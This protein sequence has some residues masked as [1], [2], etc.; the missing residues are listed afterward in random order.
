MKVASRGRDGL[1]GQ[2]VIIINMCM[3]VDV[4]MGFKGAAVK[5]FKLEEREALRWT[6]SREY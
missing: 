3:V 4:C 6:D 1:E 5:L 2:K